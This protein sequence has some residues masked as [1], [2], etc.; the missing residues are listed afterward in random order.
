VHYRFDYFRFSEQAV[1]EVFFDG[2]RRVRVRAILHP[3]RIIGHGYKP[4][5]GQRK[6][7]PQ[8]APRGLAARLPRRAVELVPRPI[9]RRLRR[10]AR[11]RARAGGPRSG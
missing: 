10:R 6:R 8:P 4:R 2:M 3:P 5:Q 9:R 7:Q 1:R 11:R